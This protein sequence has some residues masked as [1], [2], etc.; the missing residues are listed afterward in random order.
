MAVSNN[1]VFNFFYVGDGDS[2]L[3]EFPGGRIFGVIDSNKTSWRSY[4][5]PVKYLERRLKEHLDEKKDGDIEKLELAFVCVSHPHR[6]HVCGLLELLSLQ[7]IVI[8]EFW[9]SLPDLEDLLLKHASPERDENYS[10]WTEVS[11]FYYED[12]I[13]EFIEFGQH[14]TKIVGDERTR[15]LREM[16]ALPDIEGVE[17]YV[18]NP[19]KESLSRYQ[20]ELD[21]K[22]GRLEHLDRE[23]IDEISV[24]LLFVYGENALLYA[25]DM[26]QEQWK[27]VIN[28]LKRR[29]RFK[30]FMPAY[31]MKAS[32]H[33]GPLSFYDDLWCDV[34]GTNGGRIVVSGGS[35]VHPSDTLI[36]S[37][38]L[39][40]KKLYCTGMAR[41]C[42]R[43]KLKFDHVTFQN[44]WWWQ[45]YGVRVSDHNK[46]CRGDIQITLPESGPIRVA[47]T[48]RPLRRQCKPS[49]TGVWVVA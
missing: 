12:Q 23:I 28:N 48:C 41:K 49:Q 16:Q 22:Y 35:L 30:D 32:H 21:E 1:L 2:T 43:D 36:M 15:P 10:V 27:E 42:G 37:A 46:P 14:I 44:H 3:I 29:N 13:K 6:D 33:G 45:Q 40:N 38:H 11:Q 17:I 34:L 39:A 31:V 19:T 26:Q 8:R 20:K 47:T 24:A 25:S 18:L 7:G 5:P 9:H 4:S